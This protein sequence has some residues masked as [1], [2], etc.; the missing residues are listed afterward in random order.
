MHAVW[1]FWS[2]PFYAFKGRIWREPVHHL[3]AWGLSLRL[4]RKHYPETHL[5]TDEA[6]AELLV[7]RLGLSFTHVR[8]DLER[9]SNADIGWWALGKLLAYSLQDRPFVHM[10][11]DVFL[12]K[13]LPPMLANAAVFA[14][15]PEDHP[16]DEW[17]GPRDIEAAFSKHAARLP[18]EWEW[19]RSQQSNGFREENCGIVGGT[20]VD[21]IRYY[22]QLALDLVLDPAHAGAWAELPDKSGYNMMIEQFLLAACLDYHRADPD[23][24]YRGI[25]AKYLF[26]SFGEAFNPQAAA[27]V[28]YT[29]LMG[30]AKGNAVIVRRLEQRVQ[31]EDPHFYRRC[32][33]LAQ[34]A[35]A[36]GRR[37][38]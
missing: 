4:A 30:D 38:G 15:C 26:P 21:F 20:R 2:K 9:L 34:S 17:C 28:G 1:S 16:V 37:V 12:W 24:P 31:R 18:V 29:H 27:R 33:R 11:S 7:E 8:T 36:A 23:S 25:R 5:V 14:Q 22:A 10:D 32:V 35:P 6:G 13:L 3:L 19:V